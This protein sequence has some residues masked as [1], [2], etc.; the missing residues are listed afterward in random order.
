MIKVCVVIHRPCVHAGINTGLSI[1]GSSGGRN[2]THSSTV[3]IILYVQFRNNIV[4]VTP[5]QVSLA[6][7]EKAIIMIWLK[8]KTNPPSSTFRAEAGTLVRVTVDI[9]AAG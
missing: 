8:K 3:T 1:A 4:H 6:L 7:L 2:Q 9:N 5:N